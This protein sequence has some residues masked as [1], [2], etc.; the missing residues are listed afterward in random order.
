MKKNGLFQILV[1]LVLLVVMIKFVP[2][3]NDWARGNLPESVLTLI[4]EEPQSALEKGTDF[5]GKELKKGKD[6]VGDLIDKI[7]N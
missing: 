7:K 6:A 1:I 4:G 2:P 5:L 3:V